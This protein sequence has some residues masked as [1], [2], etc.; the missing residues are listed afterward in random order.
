MTTGPQTPP[1]HDGGP[2]VESSPPAADPYAPPAAGW[3]AWQGQP[4]AKPRRPVD[5]RRTARHA[6]IYGM[7][8]V[9][10]S[11][12]FF[13]FG[14]AFDVLAIVLGVRAVRAARRE[15][16]AP[17]FNAAL[18]VGGERQVRATG[19]VSGIVLG[20]LGIALVVIVLTFAAIFWKPIRSY[21]DC[22]SGAN[23]ETAKQSCRDD[24]QRSINQHLGR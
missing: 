8:G 14:L 3:Q 7:A 24:L 1:G 22:T 11:V 17:Q 9:V 5:V 20:S 21:Y 15:A 19:A 18:R 2:D 10:L 23:T 13:P 4:P 12:L 6:L 16:E